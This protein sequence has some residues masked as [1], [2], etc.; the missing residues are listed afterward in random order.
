[1][2]VTKTFKF[3]MAHRLPKHT[4]KCQNIHGHTYQIDVKVSGELDKTKDSPS[5]GM[6]I[7]F[8]MLKHI[9]KTFIDRYLDHYYLSYSGDTEVIKFMQEQGFAVTIVDFIPT[10][11]NMAKWVYNNISTV[12]TEQCDAVLLYSVKV[13]E[14]PTSYAEYFKPITKL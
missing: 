3:D 13:W 12:L 2:L 8:S 6:V 10:A 4:G 7:D 5:E 9:V 11:E 14:T 1:M